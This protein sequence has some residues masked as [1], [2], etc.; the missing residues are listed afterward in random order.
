MEDNSGKLSSR[1]GKT[2]KVIPAGLAEAKQ[3]KSKKKKKG[4]RNSNKPEVEEVN[5][6]TGTSDEEKSRL[7]VEGVAALESKYDAALVMFS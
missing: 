6:H 5:K 7:E 4:R 3:K 1:S 2:N